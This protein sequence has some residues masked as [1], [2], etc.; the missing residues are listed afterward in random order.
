LWNVLGHISTEKR[1][2]ALRNM[3]SLLTPNGAIFLDVQSRYNAREYGWPKTAARW[4]YDR[5]RPRVANGD[6]TVRWNASPAPILTIGHVFTRPEMLTL[7]HEAGL[8][9]EQLFFVDYRS[10]Q[11]QASQF[12]GSMFFVLHA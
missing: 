5:L 10:G 2:L 1:V 8:T 11:Q 4:T 6:V 9:V 3:R 7:I 12:A